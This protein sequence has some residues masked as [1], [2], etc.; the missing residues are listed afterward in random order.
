MRLEMFIE[1]MPAGWQRAAIV[2][3]ALFSAA[4]LGLLST[5]SY[6]VVSLLYRFGQKSTALEFPMWIPQGC[7]L[8]GF[9]LIA[10]MMLLRLAIHGARLSQPE[11]EGMTEQ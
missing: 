5:S 9:A 10:L 8:A 1:R 11:F 2:F 6:Q 4:M 3:T 7:V